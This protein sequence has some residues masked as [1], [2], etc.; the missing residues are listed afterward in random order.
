VS[1]LNVIKRS[2]N[3][4]KRVEDD[5]LKFYLHPFTSCWIVPLQGF[6]PGQHQHEPVEIDDIIGKFTLV[7]ENPIHKIFLSMNFVSV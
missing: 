1:L 7:S 4:S 3:L 6:D 2:N 5:I